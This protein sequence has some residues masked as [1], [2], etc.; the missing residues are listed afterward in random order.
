MMAL[1]CRL[2]VGTGHLARGSSLQV[3]SHPI[4]LAVRDGSPCCEWRPAR[5]RTAHE[6][7]V[8]TCGGMLLASPCP[9]APR[10][11]AAAKDGSLAACQA[12]SPLR[13]RA[14]DCQLP[15]SGQ[16]MLAAVGTHKLI[17]MQITVQ[18]AQAAHSTHTHLGMPVLASAA[19]PLAV[20]DPLA[21]SGPPETDALLV[22][23]PPRSPAM[24]PLG[25]VPPP[26]DPLAVLEVPLGVCDPPAGTQP[27]LDRAVPLGV[28]G[29]PALPSSGS[30]V[31]GALPP[32]LN[33]EG[34]CVQAGSTI[35]LLQSTAPWVGQQT[36]VRCS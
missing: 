18:N 19:A 34:T 16:S 17:P 29:L 35:F 13:Q 32:R 2:H 9:V 30:G 1:Q 26:R 33:R 27:A 4:L 5:Q 20:M 22:R 15:T 23:A 3:C 25:V 11:S 14:V 10:Q 7:H 24:P 8:C 28:L 12:L 36:P 31:L 6:Q 21:A